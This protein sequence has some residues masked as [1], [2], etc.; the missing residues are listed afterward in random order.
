MQAFDDRTLLVK[1]LQLL[2]SLS[3]FTHSKASWLYRVASDLFL[4][5]VE[6]LIAVVTAFTIPVITKTTTA[7]AITISNNV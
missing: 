3:V 6:F 4:A 5:N 2:L 7:N 1:S